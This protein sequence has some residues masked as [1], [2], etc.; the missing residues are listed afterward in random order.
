MRSILVCILL[1]FSG[2]SVSQ[3]I[4]NSAPILNNNVETV[5]LV[6]EVE[7]VDSVNVNEDELMESV[8]S[9]E[10]VGRYSS[11]ARK[12]AKSS[13]SIM[14]VQEIELKDASSTEIEQTAG[15]RSA[16][17]NFSHSKKDAATQRTQ[18]SPSNQ[19]QSQMDD[20]V[21]YFKS[22]APNSFEHHYYTFVA[23]NYDLSLISELEKAEKLRP[24][25]SDVHVQMA[26]CKIISNDSTNATKY[27]ELLKSSKRLSVPVTEYTKD[28]LASTPENGTL[29]T[30][31]F[32]DSYGVWNAQNIDGLRSDVTLVSLD[33]LQS[34]VYRSSLKKKGYS[35]P[36][37]VKI[38]VD[39]LVRFCELNK[40]KGLGISMTIPKE[41][42]L[43]IKDKIYV[44][45]L[46]FEYHEE[47]YNN[48]YKNDYLW[49]EKFEKTVINQPNSQK[50]KDLSAN[51]LP[52]LLQLQKVYDERGEEK[53][54]K[55]V[56][57]ASDKVSVQCKKYEQVQKLKSS[58]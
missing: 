1:V 9:V 56:D 45:G 21:G 19:Q 6:E 13:K 51:Y 30:H 41:Y 58:Y 39:Y 40:S 27:V 53:K 57:E 36:E 29:I 14:E 43:P 46:V 25:N 10:K 32:D 26:A 48:F 34:E 24:D 37:G 33:F 16:Q 55:E 49:N 5:P 38:D 31:G 11:S 8:P 22:K 17:Y 52:M 28:V 2:V 15:Y 47:E 44:V 35:L 7:E 23:G 12:K 50:A 54:K 42:L 3:E 20:A 18:R 4:T